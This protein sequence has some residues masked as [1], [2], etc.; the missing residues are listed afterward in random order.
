LVLIEDG[1]K[2]FISELNKKKLN[3]KYKDLVGTAFAPRS[4]ARCN[5]IIQAALKGQKRDFIADWPADNFLRWAQALGFVKWDSKT[6]SFC[7]TS[8]GLS[9]SKSKKNSDAEYRIYEYAF[10][11]YPPVSRIIKLLCNAAENNESLTKFEIGV[12][13]GFIGEEGFTSISQNLFVK[14]ICSAPKSEKAKIKS[15]WE[16]DSDK[17]ARM[18]CSWLTQL[19]YP[20]IIKTRKKLLLILMKK[21]ICMKCRL[22]QLP[23]KVLK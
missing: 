2:H 10:L 19:K 3:L 16:G 23:E 18:I 9:L 15:N 11:S 12:K 14:E 5:G 17:Y 6:D 21:I 20:W 13:L 22:I 1:R 7:I 4:S 8:I